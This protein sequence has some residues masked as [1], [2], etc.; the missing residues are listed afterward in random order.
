MAIPGGEGGG[1]HCAVEWAGLWWG[2][3]SDDAKV[4]GPGD[5]TE[6]ALDLLAAKYE[7]YRENRPDGPV[8]RLAIRSWS[9]WYSGASAKPVGNGPAQD[10]DAELRGPGPASSRS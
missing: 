6:R 7:Q 10:T 8:V 1:D 9:G 4:L 5:E 3:V 2:R